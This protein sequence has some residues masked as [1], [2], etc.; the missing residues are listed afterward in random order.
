MK[1]TI[2]L[3]HSGLCFALALTSPAPMINH[4][5]LAICYFCVTGWSCDLSRAVCRLSDGAAVS[6]K[7]DQ[8][9]SHNIWQVTAPC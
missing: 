3:S 6:M 4:Q 7:W 9:G 1:I 5:A 8:S 2:C